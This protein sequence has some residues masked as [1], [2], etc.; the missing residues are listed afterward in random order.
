LFGKFLAFYQRPRYSIFVGTD[1]AVFRRRDIILRQRHYKRSINPNQF[2]KTVDANLRNA[3][4]AVFRWL[5]YGIVHQFGR[6]KG[7]LLLFLEK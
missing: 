7:D 5:L 2:E 1:D 4:Y 3:A 6:A